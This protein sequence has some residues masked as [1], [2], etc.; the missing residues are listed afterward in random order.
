MRMPKTKLS[1]TVDARLVEELDELARDSSRSQIVER[2]LT[3]WLRES[4]RRRLEDEIERYYLEMT[5]EER[6]EDRQWADVA[7]RSIK[8]AWS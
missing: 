7:E 2:A 4:R 3:R 5:E 8:R 6:A 1:V